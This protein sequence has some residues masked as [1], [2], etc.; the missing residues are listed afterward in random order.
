MLSLRLFGA[1]ELAN[2]DG[3]AITLPVKKD[4]ALLALLALSGEH[5]RD[6]GR[7][8][9]LL[10]PDCGESQARKS[11][12]Q[13]LVTLR[14]A[15]NAEKELLP[16]DRCQRLS[17]NASA[18][19]VD[20]QCFEALVV[21]D[22]PAAWQEAAQLYRGTLL[23][24][25]AIA[26]LPFQNWLA[27]VQAHFEDLACGVL[28]RLA[29]HRLTEGDWDGAVAAAQRLIAIDPARELG[30]RLVM[31]ALQHAGRRT[32]ALQQFHRL[33]GV[34]RQELDVRP[35]LDTMA[36]Y[37]EIKRQMHR[38]AS[39]P[40]S[41]HMR[42]SAQRHALLVDTAVQPGLVVLPLRCFDAEEG[43][44]ALMDGLTEELIGALAAY[45]WFFVI[46]AL[47]ATTYKHKQVPP[48]QLAADLGV[49]YVLNGS[50]RRVTQRFRLRLA[51]SE[52]TRG[53]H[54][55]SEGITCFHDEVFEAQDQL[56]QQAASIIE[57]ELFRHEE[58]VVLRTP[59]PDFDA[60]S[61]IVR[62]RCLAERG[63]QDALTEARVL[64]CEAI[65]RAPA[66]ALSHA[67][68]AWVTWM[69]Y[70]LL[71]RDTARLVE[72]LEAASRAV[73]IDPRYYLGH[74]VMGSCRRGV[75][76]DYEG[77]I[78]S[79][80]RAMDMNPSYPVSYN[81]LISCLNHAGRP[82]EALSYIA[83]LDRISPHDPFLSFYHCTRALTYFSVGDDAAAI[84]S[85]KLSLA[86]HPIS[87][88]SE[89]LLIAASQRAGMHAETARAKQNFE[90]HHPG[91]TL[92][93]IRQRIRFKHAQDF[94]PLEDQLRS[95]GIRTS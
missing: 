89:V 50:L 8:A 19:I 63:H 51:L 91:L 86:Y 41:P 85:A 47:Q 4:R 5:G 24:D 37:Q 80:R 76:D 1:F 77:A 13:S 65:D 75:Y 38:N 26:S 23:E 29:E 30:H 45:R 16:A 54:L 93:D 39:D 34:L 3:S 57:P 33:S 48:T 21:Q 27:G 74:Q 87:L 95:A 60:W 61:L 43:E 20:A 58:Q 70:M 73:E 92:A 71:D 72:A 69:T 42:A 53:E 18:I 56:A 36:L 90:T 62:A 7:L 44:E 84:E 22:T 59:A 40:P 46:S 88:S 35:D 28:V 12:R 94:F 11:L 81:Q 49:R 66:S 2:A 82:H 32:E 83:P 9:T 14:K 6:R 31:Q 67:G 68:L 17:L 52:T 78:A 10:W 55:W 64:A 79:L 15:L 25:L